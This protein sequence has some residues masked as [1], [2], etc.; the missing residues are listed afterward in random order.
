MK[1]AEFTEQKI[2]EMMMRADCPGFILSADLSEFAQELVLGEISG[3]AHWGDVV[4][5]ADARRHAQGMVMAFPLRN[6]SGKYGVCFLDEPD[7]QP[8]GSPES[9]VYEIFEDGP[10]HLGNFIAGG[11][12]FIEE[13]WRNV[14]SDSEKHRSQSVIAACAF[15]LSVINQPCVTK[16]E[17]LLSRQQ[18]RAA[19]RDGKKCADKWTR[20]SWD[21]SAET[22]AKAARNPSFR[23]V[24]LHWRRGHYRIAEAHY[25]GAVQRPDAI[26]PEDRGLWWQ[27]I[28][29]Q[30]V[31]HPAFGVKRSIHAP[32]MTTKHLAERTGA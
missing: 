27:W 15:A 6:G 20:V 22:A 25:K 3:V 23:K 32:K 19:Q 12:T 1:P 2:I 11:V 14:W 28:N 10:R 17:H 9:I 7:D 29:P 21:L 24:P 26:R 13:R 30:W 18:R 16:P 8:E 31:G 5:P 4:I